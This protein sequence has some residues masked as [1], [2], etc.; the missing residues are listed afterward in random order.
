MALVSSSPSGVV[1]VP[2]MSFDQDWE[3]EFVVYADG[4]EDVEVVLRDGLC[5]D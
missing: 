4:G 3:V 1:S 2:V 5:A